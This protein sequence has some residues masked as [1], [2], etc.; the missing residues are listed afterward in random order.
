MFPSISSHH[1]HG[2]SPD[3]QKEKN[4]F[5]FSI[6]VTATV[7]TCIMWIFLNRSR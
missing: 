7:T 4:D 1:F 5:S 2:K 3:Q 6:H